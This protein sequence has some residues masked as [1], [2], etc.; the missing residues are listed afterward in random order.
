MIYSIK[1]EK[2][3]WIA[4]IYGFGAY[5]E[6]LLIPGGIEGLEECESKLKR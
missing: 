4:Q 3:A 1:G 5:S 2:S 6:R